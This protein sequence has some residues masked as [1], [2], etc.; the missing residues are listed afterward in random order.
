MKEDGKSP[1]SDPMLIIADLLVL[2]RR[3][4]ANKCEM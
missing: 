3:R 4:F 1:A 2:E